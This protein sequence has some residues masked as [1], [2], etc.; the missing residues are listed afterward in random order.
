MSLRNLVIHGGMECTGF[1]I[2]NGPQFDLSE[3]FIWDQLQYDVAASEYAAVIAC[4]DLTTYS[5]HHQ[6]PGHIPLR[7]VKRPDRYGIRKVPPE[8]AD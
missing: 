6:R 4:P 7:T 2:K 3:D 8:I 5:R 1:D